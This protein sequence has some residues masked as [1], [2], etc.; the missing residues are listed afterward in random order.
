MLTRIGG[1]VA[2]GG[3]ARWQWQPG[4]TSHDPSPPLPLETAAAAAAATTKGTD[5]VATALVA[6]GASNLEIGSR[7]G[8]DNFDGNIWLQEVTQIVLPDAAVQRY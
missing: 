8:A 1:G 6:A 2:Y 5:V 3:A 4:L 7:N